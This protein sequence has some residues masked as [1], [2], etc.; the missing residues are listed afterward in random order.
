MISNERGWQRILPRGLV[1]NA[2]FALLLVLSAVPSTFAQRSDIRQ[3]IAVG[4]T[5]EQVDGKDW[6]WTIFVM[7]DEATLKDISCVSYLLHPTFTPRLRKVCQRERLPGK[8]FPL[9]V[10][11]WGTFPVGVTI[12]FP[13]GRPQLLTHSLRF[14]ARAEGWATLRRDGR[15]P[16]LEIPVTA[17]PLLKEGHFVFLLKFAQGNESRS[18][19]GIEIQV[20]QDSRVGTARWRFDLF[21]NEESWFQIPTRAYNDKQEPLVRVPASSLPNGGALPATRETEDIAIRILAYRY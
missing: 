10:T 7:G 2:T 3:A 1:L 17:A 11:G 6:K 8:G 5:A 21:F 15:D 12:E 13:N 19:S 14:T 4:N 18:V 20:L 16:S 9:T